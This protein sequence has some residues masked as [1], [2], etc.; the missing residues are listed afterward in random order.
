[1]V[2]TFLIL[3][4]VFVFVSENKYEIHEMMMKIALPQEPSFN[5]RVFL[6]KSFQRERRLA[7]IRF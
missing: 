1:M 2:I 3:Y 4:F 7:E 6:S 5:R